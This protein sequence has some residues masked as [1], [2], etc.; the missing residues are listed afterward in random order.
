MIDQ[1]LKLAKGVSGSGEVE[2]Q[3]SQ[4]AEGDVVEVEE[5]EEVVVG[6]KLVEVGVDV[7]GVSAVVAGGILI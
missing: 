2:A 7:A 3:E 1:S 4:V 5:V 6:S